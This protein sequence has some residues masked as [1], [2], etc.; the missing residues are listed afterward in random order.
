MLIRCSIMFFLGEKFILNFQWN[1]KGPEISKAK[2][3]NNKV[4]NL[5][6]PDLKNIL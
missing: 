2:L 5:T 4:E 3:K 6:V 1:L